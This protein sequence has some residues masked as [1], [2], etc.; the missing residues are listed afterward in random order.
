[1]G[2]GPG[3]GSSIIQSLC[4]TREA[5]HL[6]FRANVSF[7][8][9]RSQIGISLWCCRRLRRLICH[10]GGEGQSGPN[11]Q[12]AHLDWSRSRFHG[13]ATAGRRQQEKTICWPER[14][15]VRPGD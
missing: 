10:T 5:Q 11:W 7:G 2:Y 8:F 3:I 6:G 14:Q 12:R 9:Y 13:T 4:S 15:R 1:M